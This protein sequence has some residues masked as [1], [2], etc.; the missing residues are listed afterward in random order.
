MG[1]LSSTA[2]AAQRCNPG[3][4]FLVA[5]RGRSEDRESGPV[6][7]FGYFLV[8]VTVASAA[9]ATATAL[10]LT[11]PT[12]KWCVFYVWSAVVVEPHPLSQLVGV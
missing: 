10:V 7:G 1:L 9:A 11:H 3:N 8:G 4:K 6:L 5:Q 12:G 2:D